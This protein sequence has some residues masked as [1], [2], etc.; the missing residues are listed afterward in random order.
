MHTQNSTIK[1]TSFINV[2]S[3]ARARRLYSYVFINGMFH[4]GIFAWLGYFFYKNYG[5]NEFRT[6]LALLGYGIPGLLL[7]P[8]LGRLA[9][10][11]GRSKIMPSGLFLASLTVLFLSQNFML[12][13]SCIL[14][15]LLSLGFD[16]SHPLFAAIATTLSPQK[17][18]AVGLFAF[19]LFSG[20]G[21][22]SLA[23][24]LIINIGLNYAFQIYG[25]ILFIAAVSSIVIFKNEK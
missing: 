25:I 22:G 9:D 11:Y 16:L 13:V 20:Y 15:G 23:I 19:F 21:F 4:S 3:T 1:I 8:Q 10:R 12:T 6:G 5:L 14:I 2:L 18:I 17:G 7:G 24:S